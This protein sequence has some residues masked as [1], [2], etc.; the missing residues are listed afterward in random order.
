MKVVTILF[1]LLFMPVMSRAQAPDGK[2]LYTSDCI[3]CHAADGSGN[4]VLGRQLLPHPA[5]DLRPRILSR[6][7][8]RQT[9]MHGR[10][11]TG[12]HPHAG[13]LAPLAVDRLID[14][15]LS[16]SYRARPE[17]GRKLFGQQ[18]ARCHGADAK[19]RSYPGAPNLILSELSDIG[20]AHV[21]RHGHAG[22]IMGGFKAELSNAEIAD[23]I[24]WLKL[25]RYRLDSNPSLAH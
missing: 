8:I 21:I 7:E 1:I 3:A 22:T 15:I 11:K 24:V 19:G 6:K 23:T 14:Y 10:Q 17:R 25:R 4:T 2:A 9:I 12:M 5:R 20:M 13:K 16:F 18:C